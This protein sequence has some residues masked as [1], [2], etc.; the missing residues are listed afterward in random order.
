MPTGVRWAAFWS[1]LASGSSAGRGLRFR[2][3]SFLERTMRPVLQCC[4][5]ACRKERWAI[6]QVEC[7]QIK[8]PGNTWHPA[9]FTKRNGGFALE[10]GGVQQHFT[11][12]NYFVAHLSFMGIDV[13]HDEWR[14]VDFN[15]NVQFLFELAHQCGLPCFTKLDAAAQ[16]SNT[17]KV[18]PV[19]IHLG[20]KQP[21]FL[22]VQPK[23]FDFYLR[24][25]SPLV[26]VH[27]LC[28]MAG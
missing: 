16:R 14:S 4:F 17:L 11:Q 26:C 20:C 21:A 1:C 24:C 6:G 10:H 15:V 12:K 19:V 23:C 5:Q 3:R 22:P 28:L 18:T 2:T 7:R 25:W 8:P 13:L 27:G 9:V